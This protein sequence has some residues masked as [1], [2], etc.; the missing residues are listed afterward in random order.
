VHNGA[1][2]LALQLSALAD[3]ECAEPFEVIVVLNRCTDES[4]QVARHF[5]ERLHLTILEANDSASAAYARNTGVAASAADSILFCDADDRV[6]RTWVKEMCRALDRA[7]FVG[8]RVIV[9]RTGLADWAYDRFYKP[10][11]RT[12]LVVHDR[13][14]RYPISASLG[15]RKQALERVGG[16]E[17]TF[18]GA[19]FEETDLAI[20]LFRAGFVAGEAPAAELLYRPRREFRSLMRQRRAYAEGAAR[21]ARREGVP[22]PVPPLLAEIRQTLRVMAHLVMRKREWRP[23]VLGSEFL[24]RYYKLM[25][26]R[27]ADRGPHEVPYG[28]E[29]GVVDFVVPVTTSTIGGRSLM[30]RQ[31]AARWYAT[32]GIEEITLGI[33]SSLLREADTFLDVGANIGSFS[34]CAGLCVGDQGSVIAFEPDPRTRRVLSANLERHG[35]A[36]RS[37]V[38]P[39]AVGDRCG[40][41]TII[42]FDND[43]VT[44]QGAAPEAFYPGAAAATIEVE[45]VTL[46]SI[47]TTPVAMVKIDVEGYEIDV[48]K[49]AEGLLARSPDIILIVELNPASQRAVDRSPEDLV[50][51]LMGGDRIAWLIE[52]ERHG[53][54]RRVGRLDE[55][56]LAAALTEDDRWYANILSGPLGRM[57]EIEAAIHSVL[58]R[59]DPG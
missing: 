27:H 23:A 15:C 46:D 14:I 32:D 29:P 44:G 40:N 51:L 13:R 1:E 36:A 18:P 25:A 6:G 7:D 49:G 35:V 37:R 56:V 43:L 2:T 17:E 5:A 11:D 52:E 59:W 55:T 21:L 41:T 39:Y 31:T 4:A 19:A 54:S 16:F 47:V 48:L 42:Q 33:M 26:A 12:C 34:V 8:G 57:Q 22:L 20:R 38:Q 53:S 58:R 50:R 30:A 24:M 10:L 28:A 3:Q 9:D 45:I